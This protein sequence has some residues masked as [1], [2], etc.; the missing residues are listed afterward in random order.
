MSGGDTKT[1]RVIHRGDG[2][3]DVWWQATPVH[4]TNLTQ[5]FGLRVLPSKALTVLNAVPS[6]N[7]L[8]LR[9][10][11]VKRRTRARGVG[12]TG[13]HLASLLFTARQAEE[14]AIRR[15]AIADRE[16]EL[17]RSLT[18]K[19]LAKIQPTD[20]RYVAKN[21]AI[22]RRAGARIWNGMWRRVKPLLDEEA[23]K[24]CY[25]LRTAT[26]NDYN[27]ALEYPKFTDAQRRVFAFARTSNML[28]AAH[29]L[30]E[31]SDLPG[32]FPITLVDWLMHMPGTPTLVPLLFPAT[33]RLCT[34]IPYPEHLKP[35]QWHTLTGLTGAD[36]EGSSPY[37]DQFLPFW[38][39]VAETYCADPVA[40]DAALA[41]VLAK[42]QGTHSRTAKLVRVSRTLFFHWRA[43][44]GIVPASFADWCDAGIGYRLATTG[45]IV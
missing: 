10:D 12:L 42:I 44:R 45:G 5:T 8:H 9:F 3:V 6:P 37:R 20:G 2:S 21:Y 17:G 26:V 13:E 11:A 43:C 4:S 33:P 19:E 24:A 25:R 38:R 36:M 39:H 14:D 23:L 28:D 27:D 18:R 16:R 15:Q 29:I 41:P 7:W 31:R 1:L 34:V 40:G 22:A 30:W 35:R 32:G